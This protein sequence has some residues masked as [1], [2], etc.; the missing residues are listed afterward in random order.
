MKHW[1][2]KAAI[3]VKYGLL[4]VGIA[5]VGAVAVSIFGSKVAGFGCRHTSEP[6]GMI[7]E[8]PGCAFCADPGCS[9][10][11]GIR[12]PDDWKS[13]PCWRAFGGGCAY[14]V[15]FPGGFLEYTSNEPIATIALW[16]SLEHELGPD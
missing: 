8:V 2:K 7:A 11:T 16:D 15:R 12:M 1:I 5:L 14:P 10:S 4:V 6:R 13:D 9:I 3:V